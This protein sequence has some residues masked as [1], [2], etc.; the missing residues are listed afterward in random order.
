MMYHSAYIPDPDD[1]DWAMTAI[2]RLASLTARLHYPPAGIAQ[3]LLAGHFDELVF[4][5]SMDNRLRSSA[6]CVYLLDALLDCA[7]DFTLPECYR[8]HPEALA[9]HVERIAG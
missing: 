3:L 6:R 7:G 4:T 5:L 1:A 2:T 9:R 8:T